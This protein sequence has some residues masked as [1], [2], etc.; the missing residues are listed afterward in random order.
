MRTTAWNHQ[1]AFTLVELL[2]VIAI[3]GVL[4]ALLLPAVQQA[5]EAARRMQCSN[6][7]KQIGLALHMHHDTYSELVPGIVSGDWGNGGSVHNKD[8][9]LWSAMILPYMEQQS[10]YDLAGIGQGAWPDDTAQ[11]LAACKTELGMY[12]CPSA[13][14]PTQ[15]QKFGSEEI[16]ASNYA[17]VFHHADEKCHVGT[18]PFP[19][20]VRNRPTWSTPISTV[21][22][23]P[24]P[25]KGNFGAMTDGTSNQAAVGEKCHQL[26]NSTPGAT[27]WAAIQ[28]SDDRGKIRNLLLTGRRPLNSGHGDASNSNHPGGGLF[29]FYDGSVRFIA[30]TIFHDLSNEVDSPYEAM[31]AAN[32][33]LVFEYE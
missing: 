3:I 26:G 30:E 24:F 20:F 9:W 25:V 27:V 10:L 21:N 19:Q 16:A 32:D 4:I 1:R 23:S 8:G 31:L 28:I 7:L 5:R 17:A 2:V 12:S 14:G 29:L 6:N 33:G 13:T 18:G 15:L 22:G 11:T